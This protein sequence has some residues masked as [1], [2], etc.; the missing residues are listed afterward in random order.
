MTRIA[1]VSLLCIASVAR[2]DVAEDVR[3]KQAG[4]RLGEPLS[5]ANLKIYPILADG[6]DATQRYDTLDFAMTKGTAQVSEVGSGEVPTLSL[7]NKGK[8]PLFIMTGDIVKGAKQ[9]RISAHDVLLDE[10]KQ[11]IPLSV[12]CVEQGR[13]AGHNA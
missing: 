11:R 5:F 7:A 12:Y 3:G 9:D 6:A 1:L 8:A 2:A 4:W 10:S 13:W